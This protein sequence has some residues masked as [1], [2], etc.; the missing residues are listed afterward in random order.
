MVSANFHLPIISLYFLVLKHI[1]FNQFDTKSSLNL[2]FTPINRVNMYMYLPGHANYE[3][4][5]VLNAAIFRAAE[6]I[7]FRWKLA[8]NFLRLPGT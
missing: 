1:T 6:M 5:P 8:T 7:I 2:P 3:H 4:I